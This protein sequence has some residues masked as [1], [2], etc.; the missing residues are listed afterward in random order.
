MRTEGWETRLHFSAA[1]DPRIPASLERIVLRC[2]EK[3][4]AQRYGG[5]DELGRALDRH[6]KRRSFFSFFHTSSTP[7]RRSTRIHPAI[8]GR[9]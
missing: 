1:I 2:L 3:D 8:V 9:G 7:R 4:P 5:M 6:L